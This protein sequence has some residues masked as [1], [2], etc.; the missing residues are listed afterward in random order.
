MPTVAAIV[1]V[2]RNLMCYFLVFQQLTKM[3]LIDELY[4]DL[5][6][7]PFGKTVFLSRATGISLFYLV[8]MQIKTLDA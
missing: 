8:N 1:T 5:D 2:F 4:G 7:K 6:D 3:D